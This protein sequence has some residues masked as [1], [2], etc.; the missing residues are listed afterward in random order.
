MKTIKILLCYFLSIHVYAQQSK[1]TFSIQIEDKTISEVII[2]KYSY[3]LDKMAKLKSLKNLS[4]N[5]TYR[6]EDTYIEPSIYT[7]KLNTGNAVRIAV[8]Q[9]G[10]INLKLG[11]D[12][13]LKSDNASL[14][15]FNKTIENLNRQFFGK[16]IVDYE[17]AM[18]EQ[19]KATI[20]K[21]E[22]MKDEILIK[23]IDAME[24]KVREMGV[25]ALAFDALQ[26]FDLQKNHSFLNETASL[27]NTKQPN[28]GMSKSLVA[29]LSKASKIAI[30]SK[31]P[32]FTSKTINNSNFK[33]E[34]FKGSY[35]LIDFWASW[36]RSCRVENP[37]LVPIYSAFKDKGFNIISVSIDTDLQSLN[38]AIKDDGILW[39]NI[40]DKN[41]S[42]YSQ[43]MLSTL[44][45]NFLINPSGTI[46]ARNINAEDLKILLNKHLIKK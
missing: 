8:E 27:F 35:I 21:L 26:Y 40:H 15:D 43:Y 24:N 10:L 34:D 25:S 42:I 1:T 17:K 23:F 12:I 16:M 5:E 36:C 29:R 11:K 38:K 32:L 3:E 22:K 4:L 39:H 28:I 33:L 31:A 44:P 41:K 2:S 46:I 37:K 20:S 14:S 45:S 18:K 19:D 13:L 6:I 30:G 9:K 7:L